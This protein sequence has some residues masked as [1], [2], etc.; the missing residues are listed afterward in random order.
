MSYRDALRHHLERRMQVDL[1]LP[2]PVEPDEDGDYLYVSPEGPLV[3]VRPSM[4]LVPV[5]VRVTAVAAAE[6]KKSAALLTELNAWNCAVPLV[7]FVW[8]HRTIQVWADAV[9]ESIEPGE[10]GHLIRH[11]AFHAHRIGDVAAAV[12]GGTRLWDESQVEHSEGSA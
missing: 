8:S 10:L 9:I 2:E 7:R 6:V 1:E 3:W 11:V 5:P 12:Y 4:S